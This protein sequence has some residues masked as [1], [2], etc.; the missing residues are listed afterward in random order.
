MGRGVK[1]GTDRMWRAREQSRS[2]LAFLQL[3]P[4]S[5]APPP[6]LS[7]LSFPLR[8][9]TNSSHFLMQNTLAIL[10]P[11]LLPTSCPQQL[12]LLPKQLIK[13]FP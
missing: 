3:P 7:P 9:K 2:S 11:W 13:I 1:E 6:C 8:T 4:A 5:P 12:T 10:L